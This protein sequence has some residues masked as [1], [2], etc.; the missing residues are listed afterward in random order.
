MDKVKVTSMVKGIVGVSLPQL[1][2]KREWPM[3]GATIPIDFEILQEAI[4]DPGFKHMLEQGILSIDDMEA[5][6]K[7]GLE[8]DDAKEPENLFVLNEMQMVRLLKVA[9]FEE[10]E[11][12]LKKMSKFQ[13]NTLAN[14]AIDK[15]IADYASKTPSVN[16]GVYYTEAN[17]ALT[18]ALAN[19]VGGGD[20]DS[21][22]ETA[23]Q[24]VEFNMGK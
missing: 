5:K 3:M 21:E 17:T 23:Q 22:L 9:P 14:L 15:E 4:F 24:T 6:K 20:I 1:R 8:P 18:T 2:F 16:L 11:A 13:L 7:L 12:A 19:V 10:F